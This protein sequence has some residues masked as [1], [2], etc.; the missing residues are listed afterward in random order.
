MNVAGFYCGVLITMTLV[1]SLAGQDPVAAPITAIGCVNRAAQS[2][3]LGGNPGLPP[4]PPAT[5]G[6]LANASDPTNVFLLNG[7]TTPH[8]N[9]ATRARA[10]A[11]RRPDGVP[12]AYV[13]DGK[14][15]DVEVHLGQRVEVTGTV[16][17]PNEG[18]P[19]ATKS[20]IKHIRVASIRMLALTCPIASTKPVRK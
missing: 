20:N 11:G 13:L 18:G 5:A 19:E 4:A 1:V 17:A 7:A 15:Q 9:N 2:G 6:V 12:T 8:A 10:A 3:S 14:P 16:L